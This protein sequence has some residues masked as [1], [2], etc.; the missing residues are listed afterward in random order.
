MDTTAD[1]LTAANDQRAVVAQ[2]NQVNYIR[3]SV[4]ATVDAYSGDVK[5]YQ[6]DTEDPVLKTWMKAFP[7]TVQDKSEISDTLMAH[8]RYPRDLFRSS[9]SCSRATT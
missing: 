9:A 2:Q 3:N 6:W 1:S 8:L 7:N 5:L 4:K